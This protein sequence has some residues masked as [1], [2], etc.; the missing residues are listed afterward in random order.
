MSHPK[1]LTGGAAIAQHVV[2]DRRQVKMI[3]RLASLHGLPVFKLG[4][5][6]AARPEK[7]DAWLAEQE[8]ASELQA[9]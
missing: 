3:Y 4:G 5:T 1:I 8:A 2:G 6:V 9:A 7:L